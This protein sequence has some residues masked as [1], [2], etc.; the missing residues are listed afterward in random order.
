MKNINTRQALALAVF[1]FRK[2]GRVVKETT[3]DATTN[4]LIVWDYFV[5]LKTDLPR[6]R[7][8]ITEELLEAA[9]TVKTQIDH[10]VTMGMLTQGRVPRFLES[11]HSIIKEETFP[12]KHL[13]ILVWAP[14]LAE[15][16]AKAAAVKE[17]SAGYE[18]SSKFF[19][20]EGDRIEFD[21]T[22]IE[23]RFIRQLDTWSA[24]GHN[25]QGNLVKF[26]TKHEALC[27]TQRL[28]A[29][30][31]QHDKDSYHSNARVT[32]LNFVKAV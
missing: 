9:D 26:L 16:L 3:K 14:K 15:D 10:A 12:V 17:V 4:K 5:P 20:K 22:L 31:R 21:F 18:F 7:V 1:A 29:R 28:K 8:E 27:A 19:G 2:N 25:E 30:I 13:G 24:Y 11:I 23:K 32:S 6:A